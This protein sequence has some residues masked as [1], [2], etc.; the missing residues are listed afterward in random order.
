MLS[1]V[2]PVAEESFGVRIA[3][4]TGGRA[5]PIDIAIRR[6]RSGRG[7]V[8]QGNNIVFPGHGAANHAVYVHEARGIDPDH[9]GRPVAAL[10]YDPARGEPQL[11]AW[12]KVA[13]FGANLFL[14]DSGT[15]RLGPGRLYAG[16]GPR[17]PTV[18]ESGPSTT[19]RRPSG[20]RAASAASL[21]RRRVRR[22]A[23]SLPGQPAAGQ[24]DHRPPAADGSTRTTSWTPCAPTSGSWAGSG[25][26]TGC[27]CRARPEVCGSATAMGPSG[28]ATERP[29]ADRRRRMMDDDLDLD[30]PA[31]DVVLR[32]ALDD[33]ATTVSLTTRRTA[34]S[35]GCTGT[36]R[37]PA[38]ATTTEPAD[39][40][41]PA[42]R[43]GGRCDG[44]RRGLTARRR[45]F[46]VH[47]AGPGGAPSRRPGD[48]W[49]P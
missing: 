7:F 26:R 32:L 5:I 11:W 25:S 28:S 33:A 14:N 45:G 41:P 29:A 6:L 49:W 37:T 36:R 35:P 24:G 16:F 27:S 23:A 21:P 43:R 8:L 10:V 47:S 17:R 30:E 20:P 13:A 3:V 19:R 39:H 42:D 44:D 46:R 48:P 9:G 40:G 2:A 18:A 12:R 15:R 38:V 1:Q 22:R 31:G 4:R 34:T